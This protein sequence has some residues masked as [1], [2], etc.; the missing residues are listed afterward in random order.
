M[1]SLINT[2]LE[3]DVVPDSI[4][5]ADVNP[6]HKKGETINPENYRPISVLSSTS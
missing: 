5:L 6:A 1:T 3:N 2:N 4:K